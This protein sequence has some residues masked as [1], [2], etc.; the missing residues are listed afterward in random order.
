VVFVQNFVLIAV[1]MWVL[2]ELYVFVTAPPIDDPNKARMAR[3]A[4][5]AAFGARYHLTMLLSSMVIAS[6]I[7]F[8]WIGA[9]I[10]A[11]IALALGFVLD[12]SLLGSAN[13]A[14]LEALARKL[15]LGSMFRD[16]EPLTGRRMV[17]ASPITVQSRYGKAT[18]PS[19]TPVTVL[20]QDGDSVWINVLGGETTIVTRAFLK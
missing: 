20:R 5:S 3:E 10:G 12:T 8:H 1:A 2:G 16:S 4:A 13:L 18:I 19:N 14:S 15:H 11:I 6:G 7:A 17:L 9:A